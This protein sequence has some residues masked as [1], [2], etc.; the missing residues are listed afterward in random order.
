VKVLFKRQFVPEQA[1]SVIHCEWYALKFSRQQVLSFNQRAL[2]LITILSGSL[3][4]TRENPLWEE[5]LIKLP[6]ATQNDISQQAHLMDI[7]SSDSQKQMMFSSMMDIV[8]ARTLLFPPMPSASGALALSPNVTT[9]QGDPMDLSN[10][11]NDELNTVID[12]RMQCHRCLG[13]GHIA[14]LCGTPITDNCMA[15]FKPRGGREGGCEGLQKQRQPS[16]QS[17]PTQQSP[18]LTSQPS[19][20]TRANQ[21]NWHA[22]PKRVNNIDDLEARSGAYFG[23]GWSEEETL[24]DNGGLMDVLDLGGSD[25]DK[26]NKVGQRKGKGAQ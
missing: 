15:H 11:E 6:E 9:T 2:E 13:F 20:C 7:L 4:I 5:Y 16:Y 17:T 12:R 3:T 22:P 26:T 19:Y 24:D 18:L 1:I 10:I 14:R 23:G 8:A 25:W 21:P